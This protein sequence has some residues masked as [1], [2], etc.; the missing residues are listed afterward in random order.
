MY[1]TVSVIVGNKYTIRYVS[2]G[3]ME[4][5]EYI[6]VYYN[7]NLLMESPPLVPG[8]FYCSYCKQIGHTTLM[9][10]CPNRRTKHLDCI[11]ILFHEYKCLKEH[12]EL[13]R[14]KSH[15]SPIK[16]TTNL[17]KGYDICSY[18]E[19]IGHTTTLENC[20]KNREIGSK[21]VG[22]HFH[23]HRCLDK[24]IIRDHPVI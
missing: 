3:K 16:K 18:C 24:H 6:N 10:P 15:T 17:Q 21:C 13:T 8:Y 14:K 11:G 12:L 19:E 5:I 23:S 7:Y 1:K 4:M 9:K 22:K 20:H 2:I